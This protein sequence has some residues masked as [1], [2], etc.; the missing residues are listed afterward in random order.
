MTREIGVDTATC[1]TFVQAMMSRAVMPDE[2]CKGL[3]KQCAEASG[4]VDQP[5]NMGFARF[6]DYVNSTVATIGFA[7]R[8]GYDPYTGEK[9]WVFC[10]E[11]NDE[12]AKTM[13]RLQ[14]KEVQYLKRVID[15]IV[16]EEAGMVTRMDAINIQME[17]EFRKVLTKSETQALLDS[18]ITERWL[19]MVVDEEDNEGISLGVRSFVELEDYLVQEYNSGEERLIKQCPISKALLVFG[20]TMP[21]NTKY[22]GQKVLPYCRTRYLEAHAASGQRQVALEPVVD[23]PDAVT[24]EDD[25]GTRRRSGRQKRRRG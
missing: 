14:T 2:Q 10:N 25:T 13:T 22:A 4:A 23:A 8:S 18:F 20:T 19:C 17:D 11:R 21:E 1:R 24:E 9:T 3:Y 6:I 5:M 12:L 15:H 7:I 16:A